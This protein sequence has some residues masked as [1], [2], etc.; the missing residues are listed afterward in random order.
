MSSGRYNNPLAHLATGAMQGLK[1][2]LHLRQAFMMLPRC[3]LGRRSMVAATTITRRD[4]P[5]RYHDDDDND[6]FPVFTS[7]I[8]EKS[9]PKDFKPGK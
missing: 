8:I 7:N 9:Y 4:H 6:R 2:K 3:I 1:A 5:D